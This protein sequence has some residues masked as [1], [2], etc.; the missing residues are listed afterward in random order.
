MTTSGYVRQ[1]AANIVTGNVIQASNFNNEYNALQTAFDVTTGHDH[2]G[3]VGGGQKIPP[4][5][6]TNV[7]NTSAGLLAADG[8]NSFNVRT[9]TGTSN[10]ISITNGS[11]AA[12]NP[13]IDI[14]AAYVGQA[15]ITTLGTIATGVWNGTVVT[16]QYGGTGVAN[17]G[18][19]IT[20]GGSLTVSG[21]FTLGITVTANTAVTLPTSGTIVGSADTGTVTNTMLAGSIAASK[22]VGTD[23]AT[24]GTVTAGTW[25]ATTIAANKGGTGFS[26]YAVGDILYADTTS[27]LAK[28]ADIATGN[29]L[30][31]GGVATAPS[32]GK[33]ALTTHIS[34]ILPT[35]NGG[36]GIA[37]FTAAGPTTARIYTFPDAACTILTTNAAVTVA[38]G[39]T[40]LATLTANNVILG[41]GTSNV[42]FVA[43]GTSG[44]VLTS[45][46]T[47][48]TSA[49]ISTTPNVSQSTPADPTSTSSTTGVMMGLNAAITPTGSGKIL[50][51]ISGDSQNNT[52]GDGTKKQ[53]RF[54]TGTAPINGAALTGTAAGGLQVDV[55]QQSSGGQ[56]QGFSLNAI[57]SGLTLSTAYWIDISLGAVTGGTASL[58]NLSI[59]IIEIK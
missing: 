1:E 21:A 23:I 20:I 5:G 25:S 13:T 58:K 27:T 42:Q 16:G 36:T 52:G 10:R 31:S 6:H 54:G 53:I 4:A 50:I 35:A 49:A 26:S 30:I 8:A 7:T 9:V 43:P 34:G 39:G 32:W 2:D 45:N 19:T 14:D 33:I 15:S 51:I 37:F 12:G 59:S 17:T 24:V 55:N 48:W 56:E 22:L 29:A 18:K 41:N 3:T 38:Q 44:N 40:G 28:L 46:G 57:V 47:T 11:G